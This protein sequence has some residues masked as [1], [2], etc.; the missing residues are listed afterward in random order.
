MK[1]K[2]YKLEYINVSAPTGKTGYVGSPVHRCLLKRERPEMKLRIYTEN[3]KKELCVMDDHTGDICPFPH[4]G[5]ADRR[6]FGF[7]RA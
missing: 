4:S 6:C 2:F 1:C 5:E 7:K 3:M